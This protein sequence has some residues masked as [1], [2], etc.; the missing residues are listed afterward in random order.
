MPDFSIA[1]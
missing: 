1:R